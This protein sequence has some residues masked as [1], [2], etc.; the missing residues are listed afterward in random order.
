MATKLSY[1]KGKYTKVTTRSESEEWINLAIQAVGLL[2]S[3]KGLRYLRVYPKSRQIVNVAAVPI[4]GLSL[5]VWAGLLIA[6]KRAPQ[7]PAELTEEQKKQV[8]DK[9]MSEEL[10]RILAKVSPSR[11]RK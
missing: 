7:E 3:I 4:I 10:D 9:Y 11:G 8:V 6:R 2:Y 5:A 1:W